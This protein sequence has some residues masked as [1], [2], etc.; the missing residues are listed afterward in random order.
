[1]RKSFC[2]NEEDILKI[3]N[4]LNI[5]KA[6]GHDDS[7]STVK[8]LSM[9]FNNCIKTVIFIEIWNRSNISK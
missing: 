3:I 4:A 8:C 9:I 2:F 1:M 7:K 6:H 5:N